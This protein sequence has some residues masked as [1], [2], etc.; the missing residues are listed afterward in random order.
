MYNY[1]IYFSYRQKKSLYK[2]MYNEIF[3]YVIHENVFFI[4]RED[5]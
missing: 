3:I 1:N 5:V 4:I 2:K